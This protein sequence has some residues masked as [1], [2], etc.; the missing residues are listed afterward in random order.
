MEPVSCGRRIRV[1]AKILPVDNGSQIEAVEPNSLT[2][3]TAKKHRRKTPIEEFHSFLVITQLR[4]NRKRYASITRNHH[5]EGLG[6]SNVYAP[7]H[8][9]QGHVVPTCIIDV[10]YC[11][12][13]WWGL[14][15]ID[16]PER[17]DESNHA[18]NTAFRQ[19]LAI[20]IH[21]F[22]FKHLPT[23]TTLKWR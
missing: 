15:T 19:S 18:S 4:Q 8:L 14:G 7:D 23:M 10:F 1:Y 16:Q 12:F 13:P 2:I 11:N 3:D 22:I 20:Q 5:V 21:C 9:V 6:Q 17:M